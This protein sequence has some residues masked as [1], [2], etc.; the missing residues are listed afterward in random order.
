MVVCY[1]RCEETRIISRSLRR[2]S[3]EL[4][5][6]KHFQIALVISHALDGLGTVRNSRHYFVGV[7]NFW[8][9]NIFVPEVDSIF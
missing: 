7:N 2:E 5:N 1:I 9:G 3:N 6:M 8:I 4:L